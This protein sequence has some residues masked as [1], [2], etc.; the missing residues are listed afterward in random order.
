[1]TPAA[2]AF[3]EQMKAAG[4][5]LQEYGDASVTYGTG[6][7]MSLNYFCC[8][9]QADFAVID[10]V[11]N[12]MEWP[13]VNVTFDHPVWRIDSDYDTA[14]HFSAIVM[15]DESS[16]AKMGGLVRDVESKIRA[17][18]VDIHV[19]RDQQEPFHSTLAVVSGKDFPS[20]TGLTAVNAA[21]PPGSGAW[22]KGLG[23]TTLP[24]PAMD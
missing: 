1:M 6:L 12:A 16:Q 24:P 4:E 20:A 8:Y 18:G 17:R 15:L 21:I 19:P 22:T 5:I 10:E 9:S 14:D 13:A 7:H 23:P 3:D 11:I 2:V